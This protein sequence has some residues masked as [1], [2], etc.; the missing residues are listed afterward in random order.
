MAH[1]H[2]LQLKIWKIK[3]MA[4]GGVIIDPFHIFHLLK[5]LLRKNRNKKSNNYK[6]LF[7]KQVLR[8]LL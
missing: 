6:K 1:G 4:G 7:G 8:K 5:F 3:S 2:S